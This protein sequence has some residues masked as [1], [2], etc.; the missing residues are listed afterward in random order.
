[1]SRNEVESTKKAPEHINCLLTSRS[2][3]TVVGD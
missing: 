2:K 1:M 3:S